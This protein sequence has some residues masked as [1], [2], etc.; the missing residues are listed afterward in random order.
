M[1]FY[2]YLYGSKGIMSYYELSVMGR[3]IMRDIFGS[4]ELEDE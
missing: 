4:K 2:L 3:F 1:F